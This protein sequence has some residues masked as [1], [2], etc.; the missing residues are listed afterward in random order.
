MQ[1]QKYPNTSIP[2]Q[3]VSREKEKDRPLKKRKTPSGPPTHQDPR[4]PATHPPAVSA[5]NK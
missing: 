1:N 4:D 3:P 5:Q 2:K